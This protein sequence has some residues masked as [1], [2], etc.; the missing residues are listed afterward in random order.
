MALPSALYYSLLM[1]GKTMCIRAD[2]FWVILEI[3]LA[4]VLVFCL[5]SKLWEI[6]FF[7]EIGPHLCTAPDTFLNRTPQIY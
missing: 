5:W 3:H 4:W 6:Q 2:P 1:T 7:F